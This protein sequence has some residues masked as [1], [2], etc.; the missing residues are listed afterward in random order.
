MKTLIVRVFP[1]LFVAVALMAMVTMIW[2]RSSS[3]ANIAQPVVVQSP[4]Y[5]IS[6]E[7]AGGIAKDT[8]TQQVP[9]TRSTGRSPRRWPAG[10]I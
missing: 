6:Y 10:L 1:V 9:V 3:A 4:T 5:A 8:E 7:Q 2:S